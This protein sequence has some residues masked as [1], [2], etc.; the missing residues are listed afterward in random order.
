ML[1][2]KLHRAKVTDVNLDYMASIKIDKSLMN[3]ADIL[4]YEQVHIYNINNG[5]RFTTYAIEGPEGLGQICVNGAAARKVMKDDLLIIVTY[6]EFS[7][8]DFGKYQASN[9][10]YKPKVI[11]LGWDNIT[12]KNKIITWDKGD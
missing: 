3:A 1:K 9:K 11:L 2:S 8:D 7:S 12:M 5:E 6:A 10:I 4:E